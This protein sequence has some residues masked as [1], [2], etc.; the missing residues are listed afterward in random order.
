MTCPFS[1]FLKT[2]AFKQIHQG[3]LNKPFVDA[4][5]CPFMKIVQLQQT[6]LGH[7]LSETFDFDQLSTGDSHKF[8][9]Q[10]IQEAAPSSELPPQVSAQCSQYL[11]SLRDSGRY[12]IFTELERHASQFPKATRY[13]GEE[14]QE[15]TVW[16]S[17]DYLGMGQEPTV[18]EAC[19]AA[20]D[21]WGTGAGGTRNI[22]G[23]VHAHVLLEKELASL[24]DKEAALIFGSGFIANDAALGTLGTLFQ[25]VTFLSDEEN[26]ASMIAGMRQKGARK[27]IWRH[28]DLTHLEELLQEAYNANPDGVRVV[29]FESVYSMSGTIA[30]IQAICDLSKKYGALTYLDEVHA[31]GMYGD[32]GAGVAERD[33]CMAQ[34]DII[35]GTLGKAFGCIGGYVAGDAAVVDC[36][37]SKAPGFIFTTS[38]PPHVAA[39]ARA[40]IQFLRGPS[41]VARRRAFH[42]NVAQLKRLLR[43]AGL[44]LMEGESHITPLLIGDAVTCK[45]ASDLLLERFSVYVQPINYPTVDVGTERLRITASPVH[46]PEHMAH[47]ISALLQVWEELRLPLRAPEFDSA[48]STPT[49]SRAAAVPAEAHPWATATPPA[50][51]APG[52]P[53]EVGA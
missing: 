9:V 16:C 34:V 49:M 50:D 31:V 36:I 45:R 44:P 29:A 30:P 25:D 28:N 21:K 6:L 43:A 19:K 10:P 5:K 4:L 46:T 48:E 32:S 39:A 37:R 8:L 38:M 17:N 26:H 52:L 13:F 11:D 23:T 20:V 3:V 33:R 2:A 14:T 35:Q 1:G 22:S 7:P 40:S 12:R 24:H 18:I 51:H 47:L 41:G 42:A 53:I 15:V 27:R